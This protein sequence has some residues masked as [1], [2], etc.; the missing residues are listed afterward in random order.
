MSDS[1]TVIDSSARMLAAAARR[2]ATVDQCSRIELIHADILEWRSPVGHY[3]R[4]V[5]H[6]F[7]DLFTPC[8]IR[9][10]VEKISRLATEDT[11]WINVDFTSKTQCLSQKLLMWAQYASFGCPSES[12]RSASSIRI[13]IFDKLAGK[14]WNGDH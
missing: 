7:L 4:V 10:V 9:R 14:F 12:K 2:L 3:D 13:P 8:C 11:L 6:F 5:T 1:V